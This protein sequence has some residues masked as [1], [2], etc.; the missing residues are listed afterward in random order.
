MRSTGLELQTVSAACMVETGLLP[1]GDHCDFFCAGNLQPDLVQVSRSLKRIGLLDLCRPFNSH[2]ELLAA[3]RQ[4]KQCTY[5]PLLGMLRSYLESRW[6]VLILPWVVGVRGMVDV[7]SVYEILDFLRVSTKRRANIVED[8]AIESVK[9]LYSLHQIRYQALNLSMSRGRIRPSKAG[10]QSTTAQAQHGTFDTDDPTT[11]CNSKRRRC[12]ADDY[13][14]MR[15]RWKKMA[16]DTRGSSLGRTMGSRKGDEF[17]IIKTGGGGGV[18]KCR[19]Q[20]RGV[21]DAMSDVGEN[22]V[23]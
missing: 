23:V 12:A 1:P 3:A 5:G 22:Q 16:S 21:E 17:L 14:E 9:A 4:R 11:R 6:Q 19:V 18:R 20:E 10:S 2:S 13:G 8:V 15:Q 7:N